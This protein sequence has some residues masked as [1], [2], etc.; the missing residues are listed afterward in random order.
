MKQVNCEGTPYEIGVQHGKAARSEICRG[1]DFYADLFS[2]NAGVSWSQA[3]DIAAK[4]DALLQ[5]DWP[6]YHEEIK[7]EQKMTVSQDLCH[8]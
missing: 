7:G 6:A 3:C 4:F 8:L 5:N 1:L 2:Q